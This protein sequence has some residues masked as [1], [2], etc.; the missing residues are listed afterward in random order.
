MRFMIL[1]K[2]DAADE[3]AENAGP[4]SD[5]L[6]AAMGKFNEDMVKAGVLLAG[7][8]LLPSS[9]GARVRFHGDGRTT[10]TDGPFTESKELV[11]GYWVLQVKS[12]DEAVEWASRIPFEGGEVEVRQ[13]SELEDFPPE[14]A[15]KERALLE[16][17][18]RQQAER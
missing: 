8:G 4:P 6:L 7:D 16:E 5:E 12:K 9:K 14:V 13:M 1:V 17:M 11:G 18:Q 15:E 10:V 3:A 2:H